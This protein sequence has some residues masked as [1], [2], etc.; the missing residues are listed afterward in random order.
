MKARLV[1]LSCL[2]TLGIAISATAQSPRYDDSYGYEG[3]ERHHHRDDNDRKYRDND[4]RCQAPPPPAAYEIMNMRLKKHGWNR[5]A[6]QV[7]GD[8]PKHP[9]YFTEWRGNTFYIF[10]DSDCDK[11][12][13]RR[14]DR[15]F[16]FDIDL[17]HL[18]RYNRYEVL[19]IDQR[20]NRKIGQ[21]EFD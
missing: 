7:M 2:A 6:V 12:D 17:G 18:P 21:L 4:S 13:Y 16:R 20:A 5:T 8:G 3:R 14:R 11:G 15:P 19:V 1:L 10:I 9:K